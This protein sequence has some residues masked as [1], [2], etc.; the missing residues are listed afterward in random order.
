LGRMALP[1]S[2]QSSFQA[3]GHIYIGHSGLSL[4][5]LPLGVMP[6]PLRWPPLF[7]E[8]QL[9][10]SIRGGPHQNSAHFPLSAISIDR[11]RT[12]CRTH[13]VV[14]PGPKLPWKPE[15]TTPSDHYQVRP[16]AASGRGHGSL[17]LTGLQLDIRSS[18]NAMLQR[19]DILPGPRFSGHVQLGPVAGAMRRCE[20]DA[21]MYDGQPS[22]ELIR[23]LRRPAE[24]PGA[25]GSKRQSTEHVPN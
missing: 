24:Y 3:D 19:R 7:V 4:S 18:P 21:R 10:L 8:T 11:H 23:K 17:G 14:G 6:T 1:C 9:N 15:G 25:P 5:Q 12:G 13:Y 22:A 2:E 16:N 20:T